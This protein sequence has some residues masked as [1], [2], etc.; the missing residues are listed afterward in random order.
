MRFARIDDN[1]REIVTA[2]RAVGCSV[3]RLTAE[4]LPNLLVYSPYKMQ[5]F[6]LTDMRTNTDSQLIWQTEWRGPVHVV[7]S[8][9]E[10]LALVK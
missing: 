4:N 8:V 3:Q 1:Q 9:D 6:L 7:N 5:L 10:A 2:L